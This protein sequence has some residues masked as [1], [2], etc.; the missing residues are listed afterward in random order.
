VGLSDA[1]GHALNFKTV[2]VAKKKTEKISLETKSKACG[3]HPSILSLF[4]RTDFIL[5]SLK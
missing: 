1:G 5:I 4:I 3:F 2:V